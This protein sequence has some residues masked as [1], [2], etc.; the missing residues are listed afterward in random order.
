MIAGEYVWDSVSEEFWIQQK[1]KIDIA[2]DTVFS[3]FI[4]P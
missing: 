3:T 4:V 1:T 2:G